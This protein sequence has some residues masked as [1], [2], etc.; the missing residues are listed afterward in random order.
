MINYALPVAANVE[1]RIFDLT[2]RQIDVI[3]QENQAAGYYTVELDA[4]H[5]NSGIYIY[6]LNT[7]KT[8][9]TRKMILLK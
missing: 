9:L 2:G 3:V 4:S 6:S 1:L 8:H 5:M 7:G